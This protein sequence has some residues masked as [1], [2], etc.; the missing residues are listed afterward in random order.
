MGQSEEI[1]AGHRI[2][3][4]VELRKSIGAAIALLMLGAPAQASAEILWSG[5]FESGN[6]LQWHQTGDTKTPFFAGIPAYGRPAP[7]IPISGSKSADYYGDGSLVELVTHPVR[8]G[9][10]AAKVVVK[11][12]ANGSEP[13]DCDSGG[14]VCKR[15]RT[16]LQMHR[17]L[18]DH[19]NA[20]PYMSE[21]WVSA[22]YFVPE[23]WDSGRGNGMLHL[24]QMKPR[25]DG[26]SVGPAI[27]VQLER[28]GWIVR[29]KWSDKVD[30]IGLD[31][32]TMEYSAAGPSWSGGVVDFPDEAASKAALADFNKGGW[33]DWVFKIKFDA[34]GSS[35]AGT[36]YIAAWKRA[37]SGPWVNVLHVKPKRTTKAGTTLDHGIGFN[38]PPLRGN[39]GGFD[40]Q[41]G[42]YIDKEQVWDLPANRV[43]YVDNVKVGDESA[44]FEEMS[45]DGSSPGSMAVVQA[46]KPPANLGAQ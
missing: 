3:A 12:S 32:T 7:T 39:N 24:L 29:H 41:V 23:D 16:E 13:R 40:V 46:P 43:I 33:T 22:S 27:S 34:R 38:A 4:G 28:V 18:S 26:D 5:D 14:K 31:T 37:G 15:R 19:Y 35:Q 17:A 11:N 44:R 21:R 9:K 36:G 8:Q 45:P 42:F 20:M 1:E 25:N 10:F 2:S 30:A 6:F